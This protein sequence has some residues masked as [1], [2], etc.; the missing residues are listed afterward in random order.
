ML[1]DV[2]EKRI[3]FVEDEIA[4]FE[5]DTLCDENDDNSKK[6]ATPYD[7]HNRP[8]IFISIYV[9]KKPFKNANLGYIANGAE[10]TGSER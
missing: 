9:W 10:F 7:L 3:I 8:P 6:D 4:R 2:K 5:T 1:P